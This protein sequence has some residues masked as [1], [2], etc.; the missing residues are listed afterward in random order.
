LPSTEN[1]KDADLLVIDPQGDNAGFNAKNAE[2][3]EKIVTWGATLRRYVEC[4]QV[5][6]YP[7]YIGRC[8]SWRAPGG[9]PITYPA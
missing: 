8:G 7:T 3:A 4:S 1:S 2:A 6:T 5:R 9:D